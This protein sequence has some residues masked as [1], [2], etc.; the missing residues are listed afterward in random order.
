MQKI[1]LSIFIIII[2]LI[3]VSFVVCYNKGTQDSKIVPES[4]LK[5]GLTNLENS[6]VVQSI[7]ATVVGEITNISGLTLTLLE[8]GDTLSVPLREGAKLVTLV[9]SEEE[10][11]IVVVEP[12]IKEI[13]F[14]EIE[15]G[16]RVAIQ[17]EFKDN[18]EI[19]GVSLNV[20]P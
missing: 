2:I 18:G 5:S 14:E 11:E 1:I 4:G 6:K 3:A 19:E 12:E 7:R 9:F 8:E 13:S 10:G 15:I 16:D 17:I 20:L